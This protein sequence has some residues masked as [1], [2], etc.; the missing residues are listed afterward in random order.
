[1]LSARLRVS[2]LYRGV[3]VSGVIAPQK[4]VTV[5]RGKGLVGHI[6]ALRRYLR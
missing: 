2:A 6:C 4:D 5:G 3:L 1:M